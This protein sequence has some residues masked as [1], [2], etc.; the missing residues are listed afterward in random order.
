MKMKKMRGV[1]VLLFFALSLLAPGAMPP[2]AGEKADRAEI[3]QLLRTIEAAVAARDAEAVLAAFD[4]KESALITRTR[5]MV[6]GLLALEGA[7][8]TFRLGQVTGDWNAAKAI[9]FRSATYKESGRPRVDARWET[10]GLRRRASGWKIVSEEDRL[11]A[12]CVNTDLR[13]ELKP[14]GG[15]MQGTSTLRIEVTAGGEDSLLLELNRGLTATSIADGQGRPVRFDREADAIVLPQPGL[16]R[17]GEARQLTIAFEGKLFNESKEQGYSQVSI[18]PGGSFASWVTNWYPRLEGTGSKSKGKI[19]YVVPDGVTVASSGQLTGVERENGHQRYIYTVDRPIDFSFAAAKYFHREATID[20]IHLGIYLLRGGDAKAD[21]YMRE[22]SRVLRYERELYGAYPFDGY[23][24]VEIP[25]EETGALEGSSEQGMNL[26][27]T[28]VLPNDSFPLLL[29]AHE[30]AHSWWGNLI[31]PGDGAVTDEGLA[32]IT[33]AM[34]LR[35]F[36]GERAARRFMKSGVPGYSQSAGQY[37]V[38][39]ATPPGKD[40]PL[41]V[42][43]AG[44]DASAALHDLA[45]TKGMFV[46]DMLREKIGHDAFVRGLRAIIE[47]SA[48]KEVTLTALRAAWE[49]ASGKDLNPFFQ[50]W[51]YRTGAPELVLN[52]TTEATDRGFVSSGTITQAGEPYQVDAEIALAFPGRQEIKS[53]AVSGA[54][55]SFSFR[56]ELKPLWVVLDPDYK[57]L[58]WTPAYRNYALLADGLGLWSTGRKDEAIQKIEEY[59]VNVPETLEGRFRLGVCYEETGKLDQAERSFK[60]VL[61]RY[62]SLQVYEPAVTLS[63]LH[64]GHVFDLEGHRDEAT[65]AYRHTLALPNE[66]NSH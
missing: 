56:T 62:G 4:P 10:I 60:F 33:A 66:A 55:T 51:F 7:R 52:A 18:A 43:N 17:S 23:S 5:G 3:A 45:D 44:S 1:G 34:C 2:V 63:Q 38:R 15:T 54:S 27:P 19:T 40:Y 26:F 61:N 16:L 41:G 12:R 8:L 31:A 13:V 36:E 64:L 32:Q 37:F 24:V 49:K 53:I 42:A 20:G 57:I 25:S 14:D 58:R 46:Y 59:V 50:Q 29:V 21:L 39:F 28:G 11:Y 47:S 6:Q 48:G 30:M 9:V 35:E 65:V 22:C